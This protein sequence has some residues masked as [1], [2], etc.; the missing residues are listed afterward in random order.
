MDRERLYDFINKAGE[1][2]YAGGGV[3]VES[4]ERPD[5]KELIYEEGEL[6]YR[7]SYTGHSRSR[8]ME[9]VRENGVPIWAS[10][11]GGG[12][13][14]GKEEMASETFGFLK[15]A[16]SAT[17]NGFQSFRGPHELED[18]DWKYTYTQEGDIEEFNGFEK[19]HFKGEL[20]FYHR[21]VGG[22]IKHKN[23]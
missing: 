15:K 3:L 13:V 1:A 2:T 19:I 6:S 18:G 8:G 17:E 16:L 7:D 22:N 14:E 10:M 12:M 4:P 23:E 20:V 21:I 11:Y 9:V 5:F